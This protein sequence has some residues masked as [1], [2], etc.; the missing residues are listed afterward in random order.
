MFRYAWLTLAAVMLL[1]T[2]LTT[3]TQPT[4]IQTAQNGATSASTVTVT[5]AQT[6]TPGDVLIFS[7]AES[8]GSGQTLNTPTGFTAIGSQSNAGTSLGIKQFYRVVVGGDGASY[9]LTA[10]GSVGSL[11]GGIVEYAYVNT[12]TPVMSQQCTTSNSPGTTVTTPSQTPT[13]PTIA[14]SF[15]ASIGGTSTS[16]GSITNY[17]AAVG[18]MLVHSQHSNPIY[19]FQQGQSASLSYAVAPTAIAACAVLLTPNITPFTVSAITTVATP[20]PTPTAPPATPTPAPAAPTHVL[21]AEYLWTSTEEAAD[22]H[23]YNPYLSM[24]YTKTSLEKTTSTA[25]IKVVH[26]TSPIMASSGSTDYNLLTGTYANTRA[27]T[28]SSTTLVKTYSGT[29]FFPNMFA[30]YSNG[31]YTVNNATP[32][33]QAVFNAYLSTITGENPGY[34]GP[35]YWF[36]DNANDYGSAPTACGD[37]SQTVF[38]QAMANSFNGVSTTPGIILNA[39]GV[40]TMPWQQAQQYALASSNIVGGEFERC[41]GGPQWN[42]LTPGDYRAGTDKTWLEAEY[43]EINTIAK[44]KLF[45]CYNSEVNDGSVSQLE[46]LYGYASFLLT[47][48]PSYAI[49]QVANVSN[50][51]T[52]R[53]YPE[54][55]LV[56]MSPL[57]ATPSDISGLKQSTGVYARQYGHCYYKGVDKG[58]CGVYVN[59]DPSNTFTIPTNSYTKSVVLNGS[60]VLD[61][62]TLTINGPKVNSLAPLTAAILF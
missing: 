34:S 49:Y 56:P 51:S 48:H 13:Q 17:N 60:G 20:T 45:W 62:G 29:R 3:Y 12:S 33:L 61:G 35:D 19:N 47:Y 57:I 8:A 44:A 31:T 25:G 40:W 23:I 46:R 15:F 59:P 24:A 21:T 4:S 39:L 10:S 41:Y 42:S 43:A 9:A 2:T 53:V 36:V 55:Q 6:P 22:P 50:P 58:A 27:T 5:L 54:T 11:S 28:C 18:T 38:A 7:G 30:S 26:Y 16:G 1:G 52:F 37:T 32:Y 14:T